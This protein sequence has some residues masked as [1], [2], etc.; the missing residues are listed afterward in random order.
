MSSTACKD[1]GRNALAG[2]LY[3]IL[4]CVGLRASVRLQPDAEADDGLEALIKLAKEGQITHEQLGQDAAI[5]TITDCGEGV[6]LVQFKYSRAIPPHPIYKDEYD[7]IIEALARSTAQAKAEGAAVTGY[8]LV[9]NREAR[10]AAAISVG[11][12]KARKKGAGRSALGAEQNRATSE[13][14]RARLSKDDRLKERVRAELKV[15]PG[16]RLDD[17]TVRL[18][19]FAAKFGCV[20]REVQQ[21]TS[22]LIGQLISRT[23]QSGEAAI[24]MAGLVDAFTGYG[25][26]Q[27]LT[28]ANLHARSLETATKAGEHFNP[29][30]VPRRGVLDALSHEASQRALVILTGPGGSGKSTAL[31]DWTIELAGSPLPRI[32]TL[33]WFLYARE[34]RVN[35]INDIICDCCGIPPVQH[36]RRTDPALVALNRLDI[37]NPMA[38]HP[39]FVL[40]L[41]GVDE[42]SAFNEQPRA[43][44]E[45]LRWF[46]DEDGRI[47]RNAK[48]PRA[49]L[50]VTSRVPE[51]VAH[52]WLDADPSGF[53]TAQRPPA[54]VEV[55]DFSSEELLLAV[56]RELAPA[57]DRIYGALAVYDGLGNEGGRRLMGTVGSAQ[58]LGFAGPV[59]SEILKSLRHPAMWRALLSLE[60]DVQSGVLDGDQA[61]VR[62]LA[63]L[64]TDGWFCRR[65]RRRKLDHL[66]ANIIVRTL[67][68]IASRSDAGSEILVYNEDWLVPASTCVGELQADALYKEARSAGYIREVHP[69]RWQ[70]RHHLCVDYLRSTVRGRRG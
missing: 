36:S 65:A 53:V 11:Q 34:A 38:P 43:V 57:Y 1:G 32:G 28:Y 70:W 44:R 30:H 6:G 22:Q 13:S 68:E 16:V 40:A 5:R 46:W 24:E 48:L 31:V 49:T 59:D 60:A 50:I 17:W 56:G 63:K 27:E 23:A 39:I 47:F 69:L 55:G 62:R 61:A 4:G 37:A 58:V 7:K 25:A 12:S 29:G 41:D 15:V 33:A 54:I 8:F 42:E 9:T 35:L 51:L 3:Q 26:T 21:G 67:G 45:T 2:F 66:D 52:E 10:G 19:E 64:F 14:K 20:D 18:K